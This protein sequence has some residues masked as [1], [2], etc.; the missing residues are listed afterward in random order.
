M[1]HA[2]HLVENLSTEDRALIKVAGF[3]AR[4]IC[5]PFEHVVL[6]ELRETLLRVVIKKLG[7]LWLVGGKYGM[8]TTFLVGKKGIKAPSAN[9][10][11]LIVRVLIRSE[12][13]E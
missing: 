12:T 4:S 13:F 5:R 11:I 8:E 6:H 3:R 9:P 2:I 7:R 1:L 10:S